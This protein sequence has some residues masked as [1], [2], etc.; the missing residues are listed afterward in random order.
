MQEGAATGDAARRGRGERIEVGAGLD[1]HTRDVRVAVARGRHEGRLLVALLAVRR[2]AGRDQRTRN[3][4]GA[5]QI[6]RQPQ[7]TGVEADHRDVV[8]RSDVRMIAPVPHRLDRT[9]GVGLEHGLDPREVAAVQRLAPLYLAYE[10]CPVG[11]A[12]LGCEGIARRRTIAALGHDDELGE[13]ADVPGGQSRRQARHGASVAPRNTSLHARVS[14]FDEFSSECASFELRGR[15]SA[16]PE[17]AP[18]AR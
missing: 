16:G 4:A 9:L 15:A 18:C 14:A 7:A 1:E 8:E 12:I 10:A 2:C 3:V 13:L 11:E 6:V 17:G 5:G